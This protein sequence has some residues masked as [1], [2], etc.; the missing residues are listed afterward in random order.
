MV[1]NQLQ[2]YG[3]GFQI[4]VLS[5]L[6]KHREFL[7]GINDILEIE[8]FDNPAHKWIVEE[9]LKYHYKYHATPTKENLS[10]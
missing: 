6:L 9:I 7:Q 4:K 1:L 5:S 10:V 2:S 8:Y 3:V